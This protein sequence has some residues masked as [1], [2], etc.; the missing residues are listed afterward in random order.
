M[1]PVL[2]LFSGERERVFMKNDQK[3]THELVVCYKG[4]AVQPLNI[5]DT[6]QI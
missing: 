4:G 6:P 2:V 1:L 5:C 3:C